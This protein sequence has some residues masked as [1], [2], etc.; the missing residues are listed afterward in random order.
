MRNMMYLTHDA[1]LAV[2]ATVTAS[3]SD[4][5]YPISNI[6]TEKLSKAWRSNADLTDVDIS[7]DLGSAKPIN[8]IGLFNTNF[9]RTATVVH[10]AGTSTSYTEQPGTAMAWREFD[11]YRLLDGTINYRFHRLRIND[12][13]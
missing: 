8:L 11:Q 5:V 12:T 10:A 3:G 7:I 6:I 13:A 1:N 9:S 4:S 2:S